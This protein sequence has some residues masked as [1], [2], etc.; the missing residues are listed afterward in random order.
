MVD[1]VN[2]T[3]S[4][5]KSTLASVYQ[6]QSSKVNQTYSLSEISQQF[7]IHTG[8]KQLIQMC[9]TDTLQAIEMMQRHQSTKSIAVQV[10][11]FLCT[12][13]IIA[14]KL[15]LTYYAMQIQNSKVQVLSLYSE[16]RLTDVRKSIDKC[17]FLLL[18]LDQKQ[19]M[20]V[21]KQKLSEWMAI[22]KDDEDDKNFNMCWFLMQ[23]RIQELRS[24]DS[25]RQVELLKSRLSSVD[26]MQSFL[27][28]EEELKQNTLTQFASKFK[29]DFSFLD[30]IIRT[31]DD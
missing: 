11:G 28:E 6:N 12:C 23:R 13:I 9:E 21:I 30:K 15:Q 22:Q 1:L 3:P 2:L 24:Y 20:D 17:K 18:L 5:M 4:E 19:N 10:L 16:I 26:N 7:V 31:R 8:F 27:M 25:R 14:F 29:S